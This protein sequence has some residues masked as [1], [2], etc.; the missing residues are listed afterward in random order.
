MHSRGD[1]G[2]RARPVLGRQIR[3]TGQVCARIYGADKSLPL[4][5]DCDLDYEAGPPLRK[6]KGERLASFLPAPAGFGPDPMSYF[7]DLQSATATAELHGAW[8]SHA[9]GS[10][11]RHFGSVL[12]LPAGPFLPSPLF[13]FSNAR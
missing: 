3:P 7:W 13:D 2:S 10:F 8:L 6:F 5:T 4:K 1:L 9:R 12:W 11:L